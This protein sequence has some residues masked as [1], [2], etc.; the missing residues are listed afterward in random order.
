ML[1]AF[2]LLGGVAGTGG[3]ST[4]LLTPFFTLLGDVEVFDRLLILSRPTP[5]PMLLC[6]PA[7]WN[8]SIP[9]LLDVKHLSSNTQNSRALGLRTL[10]GSSVDLIIAAPGVLGLQ[11]NCKLDKVNLYF[12]NTLK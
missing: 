8:K 2:C 4:F 6:E 1:T 3:P 10:H 9:S 11:K 5:C 12:L 7:P